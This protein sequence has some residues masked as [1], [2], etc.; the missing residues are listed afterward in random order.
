M[1]QPKFNWDKSLDS[2]IYLR[3][4]G[5]VLVFVKDGKDIGELDWSLNRFEFF[6]DTGGSA[7]IF[8]KILKMWSNQLPKQP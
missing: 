8:F 3:S 4:C 6:G 2:G 5:K 7:N 1:S